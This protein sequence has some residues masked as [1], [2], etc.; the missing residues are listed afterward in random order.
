[1]SLPT[2]FTLNNGAKVPAMGLGTWLSEANN[3]YKAVLAALKAGY[4]HID[5]AWIYGNEKEVGQAIRDSGVPREE[6]FVTT[7]LWNNMHR[8][9]NVEKALQESLNNLQ[10]GYIDLYLMHWPFGFPPDKGLVMPVDE[11]GRAIVDDV[12]FVDTFKAMEKLVGPK[13]RAV[14][15]SNYTVKHLEKLL[16][17]G[18]SPAANEVE[19]HPLLPQ[20]ELVKYCQEKNILGKFMIAYSPLGSSPNPYTEYVALV[21]NEKVKQ[22][23]EKYNKTPAQILLSW[24]IQRGTAVIPKSVTPARIEENFETVKLQDSDFDALTNLSGGNFY[25][26]V[27]PQNFWKIPNF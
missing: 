4:R 14:G 15:V 21:D 23:A 27:D 2:A 22:I 9:E 18:C 5:T 3:A 6:L 1:M 24:G 12:D 8:P 10:I 20:E 25:R 17:A 16:A 11:N 13:L 7:K 26:V 19:L